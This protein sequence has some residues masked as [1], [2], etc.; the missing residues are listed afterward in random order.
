VAGKI[1]LNKY[2]KFS[3]KLVLSVAALIFV[4]SRIDLAEVLKLYG[5]LKIGWLFPALLFFVFSKIVSALRLNNFFRCIDLVL[6]ELYNLKLYLLGMFYNIFL[7]GGIG[8]DGYK[9]YLLNRQHEV[10]AGKI[11]WA[12]L[13]DRIT[14]AV[15]VIY[16]LVILS[17]FITF[18]IDFPVRPVAWLILPLGV[19]GYYFFLKIFFRN[20]VPVF[21]RVNFLAIGVQ[22]LQAASA[23]FILRALGYSEQVIPYLFL[24]LISSIIAGLP[25]TIGGIGSRELTFLIGADLMGLNV[26]VSIAM[27]LM[28]YLITLF[29]SLFGMYFSLF[30]GRLKTA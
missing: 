28:F 21:L 12:T 17:Y 19:A 13:I 11:I 26:E 10:K 6:S 29:V 15:T 20:F 24:F 16:L 2:V 8:G 18:R 14:G 30:P 23:F 4:F 1:K 5:Q 25:I 7:P 22:I 3:I 27:S 9:I